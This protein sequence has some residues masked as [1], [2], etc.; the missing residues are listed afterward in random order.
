MVTASS[1]KDAAIHRAPHLDRRAHAGCST[2]AI[3]TACGV[4]GAGARECMSS[5]A[6]PLVHSF[7]GR[8][9]PESSSW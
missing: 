3:W 8:R 2:A 9:G 5:G 1:R 4:W 7:M 6:S